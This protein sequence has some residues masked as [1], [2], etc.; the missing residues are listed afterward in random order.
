MPQ[1]RK[2]RVSIR[3]SYGKA[4]CALCRDEFE[5]TREWAKF[6]SASC[7]NQHWVLKNRQRP[8]TSLVL[9][10]DGRPVALPE[11]IRAALEHRLAGERGH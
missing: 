5:R 6:C 2:R 11:D 7:R 1:N 8:R 9:L 10:V 3:V 4:A